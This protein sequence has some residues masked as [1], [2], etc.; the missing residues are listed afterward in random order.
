[1]V[2]GYLSEANYKWHMVQLMPASCSSI[3]FCFIKMQSG[4]PFLVPAFSDC[5]EKEA[6]KLLPVCRHL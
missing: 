5:L 4:L 3:I 1:M 6:I 2:H